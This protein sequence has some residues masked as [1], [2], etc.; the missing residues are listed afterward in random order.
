MVALGVQDLGVGLTYR[1]YRDY[2]GIT[3]NTK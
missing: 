1:H 2:V 3:R